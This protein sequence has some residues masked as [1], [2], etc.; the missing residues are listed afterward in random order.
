MSK[1]KWKKHLDRKIEELED[2]IRKLEALI[3]NHVEMNRK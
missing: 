3:D 1:T 2:R